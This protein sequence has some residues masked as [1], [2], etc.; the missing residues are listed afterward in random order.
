MTRRMAE[1]A[2]LAQRAKDAAILS[3]ATSHAVE[4]R[5]TL[6]ELSQLVQGARLA[7]TV[8]VSNKLEG[9]IR[10]APEPLPRANIFVEI[11][12]RLS[13]HTSCGGTYYM[14]ESIS[15]TT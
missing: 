3:T 14:Q 11:K 10:S 8:A 6:E 4:C 13:L 1:H 2:D 7:E 12:V 9:L 15:H 5:D